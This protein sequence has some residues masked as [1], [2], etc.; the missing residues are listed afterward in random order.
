MGWLYLEPVVD[1]AFH[2]PHFHRETKYVGWVPVEGLVELNLHR[3]ACYPGSL[4]ARE[5]CWMEPVDREAP[6][7][8]FLAGRYMSGWVQQGPMDQPRSEDRPRQ[9]GRYRIDDFRMFVDSV[10][11]ARLF[12]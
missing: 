9:C 6:E 2:P 11:P 5:A 8:G 7:E 10:V 12:P 1:R 3:E 4:L